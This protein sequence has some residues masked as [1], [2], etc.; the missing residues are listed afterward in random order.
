MPYKKLDEEHLEAVK[1]A[2]DIHLKNSSL[3]VSLAKQSKETGEPIVKPL[4]YFYPGSAYDSIKDEFDLTEDFLVAPL[5]QEG[6]SREVVIPDGIWVDETGK[7]Y[8]KGTYQI[9]VP[10]N[11][12]PVFRKR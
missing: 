6:T 12:I 2:V 4:N 10:L 1:K 8:S 3:I 5:V 7:Q 9:E 11:R